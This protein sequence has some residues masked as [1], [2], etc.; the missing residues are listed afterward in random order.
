MISSFKR[1]LAKHYINLRGWKTNRKIVVIESDDWGSI[2][3]ASLKS[4]TNLLKRGI[5]VNENKFTSLDGLERTDD[6]KQ[7]FKI[8]RKHHDTKG[9]HPVITACAVVANPDFKKIEASDFSKYYFETIEKTYESCGE[10][11]ITGSLE[12]RRY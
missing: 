1:K 8:L 10:P 5:P 11:R 12:R 2:R 9:N 3:M 7:L 4:Y 6:L